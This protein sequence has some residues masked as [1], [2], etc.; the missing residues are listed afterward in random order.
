MSWFSSRLFFFSFFFCLLDFF[1]V[2]SLVQLRWC[3]ALLRLPEIEGGGV[4][5]LGSWFFISFP[6]GSFFRRFPP[7]PTHTLSSFASIASCPKKER[8]EKV[9][10]LFLQY[11]IQHVIIFSIRYSALKSSYISTGWC[12]CFQHSPNLGGSLRKHGV[13]CQPMEQ[14]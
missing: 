4:G 12:L 11:S 7:P 1:H 2:N 6:S 13:V 9:L 10:F 5:K 3:T 14:T 8:Q